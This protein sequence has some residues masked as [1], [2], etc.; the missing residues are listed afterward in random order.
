MDDPFVYPSL[1]VKE[2]IKIFLRYQKIGYG[3][4]HDLLNQHLEIDELLNQRYKKLSQGQR[5]RVL[6]FLSM[7]ND[8]DILLL[9]EPF[10]GLDPFYTE[11]LIA[12]LLR[13]KEDGRIILINDHII[14][15]TIRLADQIAFLIQHE[16]M[17]TMRAGALEKGLYYQRESVD[18]ESRPSSSFSDHIKTDL[19]NNGIDSLPIKDLTELYTLAVKHG[20]TKVV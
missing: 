3:E 5:Q 13:L 6:L 7:I 20:K 11:K 18:L 15:H 8:P 10:N 14:S 9:D 4:Y 16:I 19:P 17:W 12:L 2:N 1:R